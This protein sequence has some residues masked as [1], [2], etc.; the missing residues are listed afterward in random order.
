MDATT[1]LEF[2]GQEVRWDVTNLGDVPVAITRVTISWPSANGDLIDLKRDGDTYHKGDFAP[3]SAVIDSGF[4]GD[5]GKRTIKDGDTD[6]LKFKFANDAVLGDYSIVVEFNQGCSIEISLTGPASGGDFA[7]DK[8]I[9]SLTMIWD[10][11]ESDV[12]VTAWKGSVGSTKLSDRA[13]VSQGGELTVT[14]FAG[15]PN[16]VFW[17]IF[18]ASTGSKVGE[19][20][21]H[22]SCSDDDMDGPEDCGKRQGN[23][24]DSSGFRNDWLLEGMVDAKTT[25]DCTAP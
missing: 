11:A 14:G 19:S 3:T 25:L 4:E 12:E 5:I 21:F 13:P 7:C 16:D 17:E 15:S 10:G 8:P 18:D 20:K 2:S 23:G 1:G 6:T 24:K 9:D 22:L